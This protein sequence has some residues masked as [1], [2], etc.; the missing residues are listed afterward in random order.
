MVVKCPNCGALASQG[1]NYE[2]LLEPMKLDALRDCLFAGMGITGFL[3]T[4]LPEP[5]LLGRSRAP[6]GTG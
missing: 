4:H 1:T 5:T 3:D 6:I 2:K